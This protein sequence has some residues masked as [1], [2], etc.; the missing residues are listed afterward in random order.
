MFDVN[1]IKKPGLQTDCVDN[2]IKDIEPIQNDDNNTNNIFVKPVTKSKRKRYFSLI[3]LILFL[4]SGLFYFYSDNSIVNLNTNK[5]QVFLLDDIIDIMNKNKTNFTIKSIQFNQRAFTA[6][7]KCSSEYSFYNLLDYFSKIIQY[8]IKGYHVKNNY[9][10]DID[11]PW[12]V[13]RNNN[14][15][16]DLLNKELSDLGLNLKQEI[17][18]NKLII[19]SNFDNII[20]LIKLMSD[21]DLINNFFIDIKQVQSLPNSIGLY[22]VIIE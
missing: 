11:L 19:V 13:V 1:L 17:Y 16:I 14:F 8:N 5:N 20:S 6:N 15:N 12:V 4:I 22:Q 21:L 10:L 2:D 9:V 3:I 7:L 18:N